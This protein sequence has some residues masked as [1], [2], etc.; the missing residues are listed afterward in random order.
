MGQQVKAIGEK[1]V[2]KITKEVDTDLDV[3]TDQW[4]GNVKASATQLD[5]LNPVKL[6]IFLTQAQNRG[7]MPKILVPFG[8]QIPTKLQSL[9]QR[10][11]SI[12]IEFFT[13]G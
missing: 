12:S 7:L 9:L 3:V 2:N 8:T 5:K 13:Q 6:Q 4:I 10:F 1:V 11:P